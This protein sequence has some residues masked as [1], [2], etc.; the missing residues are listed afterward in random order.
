MKDYSEV[1]VLMSQEEVSST[2]REI[3]EAAEI[4]P[5]ATPMAVAGALNQMIDRQT[6]LYSPFEQDVVKG[7]EAWVL[8]NWNTSSYRFVDACIAVIV[9]AEIQS[10]KRLMQELRDTTS[11]PQMRALA[12]EGLA[13]IDD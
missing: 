10:G 7:M 5:T 8:K 4:D 1:P 12:V 9:A 6:A 2:I 3:L 13:D 11:D